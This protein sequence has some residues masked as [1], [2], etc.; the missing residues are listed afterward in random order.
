[1]STRTQNPILTS[2]VISSRY[3][4]VWIAIA[5]LVIACLLIAPET[6]SRTSLSTVLPLTSFLA[7]AALGQML[8][9]MTGG[10]D[11]SIPGVMTLSAIMA[12]GITAGSDEKLPIAIAS[13][14]GVSLL[15]GLISGVMVGVLKL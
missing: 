1:M 5:M 3:L 7:L 11:L 10:I 8:V 4:S 2:I 14:L 13:A 12:V 6:L 15:I 9:V